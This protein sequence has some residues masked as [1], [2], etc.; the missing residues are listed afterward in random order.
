MIMETVI[1]GGNQGIDD[2]GRNPGECDPFAVG[3]LELG[4]F[5]AICRENLGW[6]LR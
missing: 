5:L 4:Q 6:L 2:L 3:L 1:F